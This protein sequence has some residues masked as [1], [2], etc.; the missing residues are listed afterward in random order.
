[1]EKEFKIKENGFSEVKSSTLKIVI[2]ILTLLVV[3]PAIIILSIKSNGFTTNL[4]TVLFLALIVIGILFLG[5]FI[6]MKRAK[7]SFESFKLII[8]KNEIIR[9]QL[10]VKVKEISIPIKEVKSIT[11]NNKG[12]IAIKG[13]NSSPLET[14]FIPKQIE[15]FEKLS[16]ILSEILPIK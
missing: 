6:G 12:G 16:E 15:S 14:I 5:V 7:K 2:P 9:R 10:Y 1:M 13:K 11:K 8:D 4:D 3:L